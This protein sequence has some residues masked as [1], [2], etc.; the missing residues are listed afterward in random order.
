MYGCLLRPHECGLCTHQLQLHLDFAWIQ[1]LDL[2]I[3]SK[4]PPAEMSGYGPALV[5][6]SSDS[7]GNHEGLATPLVLATLF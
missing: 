1:H 7:P 2:N 4:E 6:F 5:I 3:S